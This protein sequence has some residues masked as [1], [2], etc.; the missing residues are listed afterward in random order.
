MAALVCLP[1]KAIQTL[2]SAALAGKVEIS[3][4][5]DMSS[6]QRRDFF[7]KHVGDDLGQFV[8]TEFEKAMVSQQKDALRQW[9]QKIFKPET[10]KG[11]GYQ[12]VLD[13]IKYLD[14]IG[15]LTP[16][17][18]KEFLQDL[19]ADKLGVSVTPEEVRIISQ[20]AEGIEKAAA[21]LGDSIGD[22][23]KLS[24]NV[25]FF[26]AKAGMD[27]YLQGLNPSS[28]LQVGTGTIGRGMML[29]SLKSPLLN[30][31]SNAE[32]GI[33]EGLIR[34]VVN[35][36]LTGADGKLA[37]D[38]IKMANTIYQKTGYDVTRMTS[39]ADGGV[40]G[41]RVLGDT[42]HAQ[43]KGIV[44]GVGRIVEDTVFKQLMGA[45]DVA[46]ASIHFADSVSLGAK[47]LAKTPAEARSLMVDA[48]RLEPKTEQG[49]MLRQQAILDA[50]TAT[51]T[52]KTWASQVS[53]G[54]RKI[55]NNLS[56][57][58]RVGDYLLPFVKT[59]ANV[60]GTGLDY[61]GM[62]IPKA[63]FK[64]VQG[65]RKGDL[66]D[67]DVIQSI[68][69]DVT[70]AGMGLTAATVIAANLKADDF[71]GAYDPNRQQYE[72]LRGSNTNSVRIGDKWI[73]LDWFGPLSIPLTAQLYAKKYGGDST[74]EKVWQYGKG[75]KSV[76]GNLP[77]V[78]EAG[79]YAKAETQQT[80]ETADEAVTSGKNAVL[81][82]LV[83]RLV[84]S[85]VGDIAKAT[86][87]YQ[88]QSGKGIDGIKTG[89]PRL[90]KD[91]PIKRDVFGDALKSEPGIS[92]L[93]FGSRV[94]T[95]RDNPLLKEVAAGSKANGKNINFTDWQKT[96]AK[97][98][99]QFKAKVGA[100]EF[101]KASI[102]Y[103]QQL[104]HNLQDATRSDNYKQADDPTK[105]A[106]IKKA[107]SD[108]QKKIFSE[109]NFKPTKS[110]SL[111]S[112]FK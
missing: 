75:V 8:N 112:K 45:P 29:F 53:E 64:A 18:E 104:K 6:K 23:E 90:R 103:G 30:I 60:I 31:G 40:S 72:Q 41:S 16:A 42:T 7:S 97:G 15:V 19:V 4:L 66:T 107:D 54:V 3:K 58:L 110:K 65:I 83:A 52:N 84:P 27:K 35:R 74:K 101:D 21:N 70:R 71:V 88:R 98:V 1:P 13:K 77:G 44:R 61:A 73:S 106:L 102:K 99:A 20:K 24:Q 93:L 62:G 85:F 22:P 14:N 32:V 81:K 96:T 59:P 48:M 36:S 56:G 69:R 38:Y 2:K 67:K 89:I 33:T 39:L 111:L 78:K 37:Q 87:P 51:W 10:K 79:N 100:Q 108:A 9:A 80:G 63:L 49:Q 46:F 26:K 76:V 55:F 12:T 91:A 50:Q 105:L 5:Y 82:D 57:N 94:K 47:A 43:G 86:D 11:A 68:A 109:Y 34:R 28:K 25:A 95:D 92:T 17:S